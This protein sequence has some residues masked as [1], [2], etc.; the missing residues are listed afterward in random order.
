MQYVGV[1]IVEAWDE[2]GPDGEQGYG[3]KYPDGYKSWCPKDVFESAYLAI[4]DVDRD[5]WASDGMVSRFCVGACKAETV[6][7]HDGPQ[8]I[9]HQRLITGGHSNYVSPLPTPATPEQLSALQ[10]EGIAKVRR[11]IFDMLTFVISW[12]RNGLTRE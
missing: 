11:H 1:K 3:V 7:G 10:D 8:V 2:V 12:G 5:E 9:T 4:D 6:Y